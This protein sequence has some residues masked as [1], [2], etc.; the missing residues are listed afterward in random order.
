[1]QNDKINDYTCY[2]NTIILVSSTEMKVSFD[3]RQLTDSATGKDSGG[4][5]TS[6]TD[7]FL[8]SINELKNVKMSMQNQWKLLSQLKDYL[9]KTNYEKN[10]QFIVTKD[11]LDNLQKLTY[12]QLETIRKLSSGSAKSTDASKNPSEKQKDGKD[13]ENMKL[14]L[15]SEQVESLAEPDPKTVQQPKAQ[16]VIISQFHEAMKTFMYF[17][18][19]KLISSR[20]KFVSKIR[21][22]AKNRK[23]V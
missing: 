5:V 15:M 1:M 9:N 19:E 8:R 10:Q 2:T 7:R 13:L 22:T 21:L 20:S 17:S 18:C 23:M 16:Q 4:N 12:S 14:T 11:W 6:I 3:C